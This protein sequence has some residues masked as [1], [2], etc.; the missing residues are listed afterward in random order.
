MSATR[1][2]AIVDAL[3]ARA[4][5]VLLIEPEALLTNYRGLAPAAGRAACWQ[6]L[7]EAGWTVKEIGAA[8]NRH[9]STVHTGALRSERLAASDPDHAY[10]V[11]ELQRITR[12]ATRASGFATI[13]ER[14][15]AQVWALD[16][17]IAAASALRDELN[18][19]IGRVQRLRDQLAYVLSDIAVTEEVITRGS[20][21]AS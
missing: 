14:T 2:R 12:E 17:E 15:R 18:S 8:F 13:E 6:A 7:R 21:R 20:R 9:H 11:S 1:P 10:L 4:A 19:R 5:A 3:A 16:Q